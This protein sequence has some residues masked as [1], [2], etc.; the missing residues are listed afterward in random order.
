MIRLGSV[1]VLSYLNVDFQPLPMTTAQAE[2]MHYL[3]AQTKGM[4]NVHLEV[5][6]IGQ[7]LDLDPG[8]AE[9]I[10]DQ[11]EALGWIEHVALGGIIAVTHQG[12]LQIEAVRE[13]QA[14]FNP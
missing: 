4:R 13:E 1:K 8:Q 6:A 7:A 14:T 5:E 11:L 9:A 3:Y 10:T 12:R 2:V